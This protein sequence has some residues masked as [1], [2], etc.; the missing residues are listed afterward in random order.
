MNMITRPQPIIGGSKHVDRE[1]TDG[2]L[3]QTRLI[4]EPREYLQRREELRLAE[5]EL[6]HNIE[7]VAALRRALPT[8]AQVT[9]YVFQEG[10]QL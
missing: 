3:R 10:P 5:I 6:V 1:R 4:N 2:I 8:G 7:R 9:D